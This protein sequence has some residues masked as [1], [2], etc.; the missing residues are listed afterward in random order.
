MPANMFTTLPDFF[1]LLKFLSSHSPLILFCARGPER[2]RSKIWKSSKVMQCAFAAE[3]TV[4][5]L[6][7]FLALLKHPCSFFPRPFVSGTQSLL[8]LYFPLN[9]IHDVDEDVVNVFGRHN[10]SYLCDL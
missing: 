1:V 8:S 4:S 3:Q 9:P 6:A 7:K 2:G 10:M 5:T